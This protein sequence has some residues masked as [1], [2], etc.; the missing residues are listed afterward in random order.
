MSNDRA[1][2]FTG[3][4][5]TIDSFFTYCKLKIALNQDLRESKEQQAAFAASLYRGRALDWLARELQADATLLQSFARLEEKT[6]GSFAPDQDAQKQ[7]TTRRLLALRQTTSARNFQLQLD[8]YAKELDWTDD[9]RK[10]HFINGLKPQTRQAIIAA[11]PSTQTYAEITTAACR[12]DDELFATQRTG[13]PMVRNRGAITCYNCNRT[14]HKAAACRAN[15]SN[16]KRTQYPIKR[17][18]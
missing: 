9:L 13:R 11:D 5:Q 14:G 2:N 7:Q 6:R 16:A 15:P 12:I 17:E 10:S 3:K 4:Q 18:F 1:P 8:Q